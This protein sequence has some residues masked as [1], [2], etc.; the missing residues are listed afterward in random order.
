MDIVHL[1]MNFA[2]KNVSERKKAG[3][4]TCP[5]FLDDTTDVLLE[6]IRRNDDGHFPDI[7]RIDRHCIVFRQHVFR[8]A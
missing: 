4:V 7:Q 8:Q 5:G 6:S 2:A 3:A 1:S